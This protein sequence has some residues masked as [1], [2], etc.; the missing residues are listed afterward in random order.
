MTFLGVDLGALM[1]GAIVTEGI[2][3]LP[4]VGRA[5]L[6][7]DRQPGGHRRGRH[8]TALVVVFMFANLI[9]DVLYGRPGPEDPL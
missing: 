6:P 9:V 4:G 5:I 1:G 7:G 3:N 8:L 2:F